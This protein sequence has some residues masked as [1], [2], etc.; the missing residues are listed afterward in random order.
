MALLIEKVLRASD[1]TFKYILVTGYLA[2]CVSPSAHARA[3]QVGSDL[4]Q[5]YRPS[6]S[7][8]L[9]FTSDAS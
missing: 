6:L 5:D 3:I 4:E 7:S 8:R 1:V 2:K 9:A